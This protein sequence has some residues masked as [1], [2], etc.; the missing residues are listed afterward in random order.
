VDANSLGVKSTGNDV[1]CVRISVIRRFYGR[2]QASRHCEFVPAWGKVNTA[3]SRRASAGNVAGAW[4]AN[5]DALACADVLVEELDL[6]ALLLRLE[7][8]DVPDRD[9]AN[10]PTLVVDDR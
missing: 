9:D 1:L 5:A 8:D 6:E 3:G 2:P 7:L 4:A 10:H